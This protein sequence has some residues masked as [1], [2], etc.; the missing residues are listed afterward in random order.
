MIELVEE[1]SYLMLFSYIRRMLHRKINKH[2]LIEMLD[3]STIRDIVRIFHQEWC[4]K[5]LIEE[6]QVN[7]IRRTSDNEYTCIECPG[8]V[9]SVNVCNFPECL[10]C[11]LLGRQMKK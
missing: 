4:G 11:S 9:H 2:I 8:V 7:I 5:I 10:V 6:L 3:D 1:L